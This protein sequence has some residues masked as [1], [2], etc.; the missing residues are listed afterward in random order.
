MALTAMRPTSWT[1]PR[2]RVRVLARRY[3]VLSRALLERELP[4][5]RW[6][7]LFPALR[8]L[9]LAGE[10]VAGRFF[11]ELEGLQFLSQEALARF[12]SGEAACGIWS[13]SAQDPASPAGLYAP[14]NLPPAYEGLPA[15]SGETI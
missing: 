14:A 12:S 8:R 1:W 3:G 4:S 10:L 15:R 6:Q 9:E 11:E 7:A 13:L 5:C 2:L